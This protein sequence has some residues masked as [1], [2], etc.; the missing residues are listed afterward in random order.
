MTAGRL[1][2]V[3]TIRRRS[4]ELRTMPRG[5]AVLVWWNPGFVKTPSL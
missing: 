3:G 2:G 5:L 4:M 1:P